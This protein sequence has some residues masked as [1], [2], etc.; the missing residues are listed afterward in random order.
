MFGTAKSD[1]LSNIMP[2][3]YKPDSPT[4][5]GR[6]YKE[7][8]KSELQSRASD[9]PSGYHV[10][11]RV[12]Q[13]VESAVDTSAL[14]TLADARIDAFGFEFEVDAK[15]GNTTPFE[16]LTGAIGISLVWLPGHAG[17]DEVGPHVYV[18]ADYGS[19]GVE[20]IG[21]SPVPAT[22]VQGCYFAG[23][24]VSDSAAPTPTDWERGLEKA[25]VDPGGDGGSTGLL[26]GETTLFFP[27]KSLFTWAQRD[28]VNVFVAE[29][30]VTDDGQS[31]EVGESSYVHDEW[32]LEQLGLIGS[33]AGGTWSVP[34][35]SFWRN[36]A[37]YIATWAGGEE[38]EQSPL[39]NIDGLGEYGGDP[40][41]YDIGGRTS[42][43]SQ[44]QADLW[45]LGFWFK[46]MVA[47]TEQGQYSFE[48]GDQS[49]LTTA[50]ASGHFDVATEWALREFQI[51]AK[52]ET[53]A[54]HTGGN[55]DRYLDNLEAVENDA[56]YGDDHD[57]SGVLDEYT[58]KR[59]QYW[60]QNDWRC[61][62]VVEAFDNGGTVVQDTHDAVDSGNV[63]N[64]TT[65][66]DDNLVFQNFWQ[67]LDPEE[68]GDPTGPRMF[69]TDLSEYYETD[70]TAVDVPA[71]DDAS[72]TG[73]PAFVVGQYSNWDD[74]SGG[75]GTP[76]PQYE[77]TWP[78]TGE[79]LPENLGIGGVDLSV[80]ETEGASG[81][82]STLSTYKVIRAVS[83]LE[84]KGYLDCING[85]DRAA[86]SIGLYHWTLTLHDR[87]E[88]AS[89]EL[90]GRNGDRSGSASDDLDPGELPPL[91][92]YLHSA[93]G[94]F[95]GTPY[96]DAFGN[97]GLD[98]NT[99]WGDDG[100][101][102]FDDAAEK[103]TGMLSLPYRQDDGSVARQAVPKRDVD[104]FR[105]WHWTYRFAMATRV[106]D[107][108][109]ESMWDYARCRIRDIRNAEWPAGADHVPTTSDGSTATIGD[110]VTSER[111]M[112]LLVR[113][114]V[115]L[116]GNVVGTGDSDETDSLADAV[117]DA[118][119]SDWETNVD[120]A[121]W[122]AGTTSGDD[123]EEAIVD[124]IVDVM[125]STDGIGTVTQ[126]ETWPEWGGWQTDDTEDCH[127]R[128]FNEADEDED[129][130]L[131][132]GVDPTS[133]DLLSVARESFDFDSDTVGTDSPD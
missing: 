20:P 95:A 96:Q 92:A 6:V 83:E 11:E 44:L 115:F 107:G 48:P 35:H 25:G 41:Y 84:S 79:V 99:N 73:V 75:P 74:G 123:R 42:D 18:F 49:N 54:R 100:G 76:Y 68:L 61:P 50:H 127:Y 63:G 7:L 32:F 46:G 133:T 113:W 1:L 109:R 60:L 15:A 118:W 8:T 69:A 72:T 120:A 93:E 110:V 111:G 36:G 57:I 98:A 14:R 19:D 88:P 22:R 29:L 87:N 77:Q 39:S 58:A 65:A 34:E 125:T 62:V 108:L 31:Y 116:P 37:Y 24:F 129:G 80:M 131:A 53:V 86:Q 124:E 132:G 103:F 91:I 17:S 94:D 2:S 51:A 126:I 52:R 112:A 90:Y 130:E 97:F 85:Y 89:H 45:E 101:A 16:G 3:D 102:L 82:E 21:D 128:L 67:R 64:Y 43:V 4:E 105:N 81:G 104:Y 13:S 119:A 59:I 78:R 5:G 106:V 10:A 33:Q 23:N 70:A 121:N 9:T 26:S 28:V 40:L 117:D 30:D 12:R 47:D 27:D 66:I 122:S 114:H 55:D 56:R 38:N 71:Y